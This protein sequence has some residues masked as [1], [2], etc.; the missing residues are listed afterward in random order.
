M[1]VIGCSDVSSVGSVVAD[2]VVGI[3]VALGFA[4][5]IMFEIKKIIFQKKYK[6]N[7]FF[8]KIQA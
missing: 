2:G 3:G 6:K 8:S 5:H 1:V 7:I 4:A